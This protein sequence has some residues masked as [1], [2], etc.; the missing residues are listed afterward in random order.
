MKTASDKAGTHV[1]RRG[2]RPSQEESLQLEGR[3]LDVAQELFFELGYGLTSI[4]MISKKAG[5]SKRTF[6][7][8]FQDKA[9]AFRAV[10]HRVTNN[11]KPSNMQSL[12]EG[13]SLKVV[14]LQLAH[15]IL[16]A[17]LSPQALALQ[18][19]IIAEATRFPELALV[20]HKQG[21]RQEAIQR[22][23]GMLEKYKNHKNPH[24]NQHA[25]KAS[26]AAEQFL[27]MLVASPQ[28]RALGLGTQLTSQELKTWVED[29][30]D[31]F[32]NGY[33]T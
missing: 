5:I 27:H 14:L 18:R 19:V 23:A 28:R 17:A 2:G 9:D 1:T 16:H 4:E 24:E 31:L 13:E 29:T 6:Y 20:V 15:A 12:F 11:I 10:V 22:I 33:L 7:H 8:R 32:L 21:A 3:I 30:V 25:L 26:F